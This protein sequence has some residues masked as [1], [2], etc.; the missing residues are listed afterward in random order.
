MKQPFSFDAK[1][2]NDFMI[3][4]REDLKKILEEHSR[5]VFSLGKDGKL[6]DFKNWK[7]D[8]LNLKMK[9]LPFAKL[10]FV[11]LKGANLSGINFREADLLKGSFVGAYLDNADLAG[12]NISGG[13]FRFS[14][15]MGANFANANLEGANFERANIVESNF[16]KAILRGANFKGANLTFSAMIDASIESAN[17]QGANLEG[18]SFEGSDLDKANFDEIHLKDF[19]NKGTNF[20]EGEHEEAVL[21]DYIQNETKSPEIELSKHLFSS[22]E[23]LFVDLNAVKPETIEGAIND[24]IEKVKSNVQ[25]NQVKT[26]CGNPHFIEKIDKIDFQNGDIITH[27]GEVAFK[28]EFKISYNLS[29]MINREG[30][31]INVFAPSQD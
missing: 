1:S 25:L 30:K 31:L 8:E 23:D 4:K 9:N 6:A 29:L 12:A 18:T 19:N 24:L 21:S 22:K 5:W 7:L 16:T 13:D 3:P 20:S 28:L 27:D 15:C 11:S 2:G 17:F 14:K 10:Q 26:L